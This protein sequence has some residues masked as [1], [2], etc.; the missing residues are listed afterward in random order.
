M[1]EK[2]NWYFTFGCGT[3]LHDKYTKFYGTFNEAREQQVKYY[4]TAWC[5]QESEED[6][7]GKAEKYGWTEITDHEKTCFEYRVYNSLLRILKSVFGSDCA[8]MLAEKYYLPLTNKID[9]TLSSWGCKTPWLEFTD[10]DTQRCFGMVL[11][12]SVK[13]A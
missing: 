8:E 7:K 1:D 6:F 4:G 5:A 11:C 13:I 3:K 12:E 10:W 2:Q 9:E